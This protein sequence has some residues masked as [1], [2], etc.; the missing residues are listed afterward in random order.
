MSIYRHL[1]A[2][3]LAVCSVLLLWGLGGGLCIFSRITGY[4]CPGCGMTRAVLAVLRGDLRAAFS[5]HPLWVTLPAVALLLLHAVF[6]RTFEKALARTPLSKDVFR[7]IE[8][9]TAVLLLAAF[10]IVYILRLLQGFR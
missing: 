4:P 1:A 10:L 9:V 8:S 6:P 7:R 2:L 5:F 3:L